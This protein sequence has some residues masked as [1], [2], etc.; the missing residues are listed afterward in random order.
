[1]FF[2]RFYDEGLAQASYLIGCD[3]SG[4]AVVVD[5]NR[6][7][8]QYLSA[9]AAERLRIT[10]VAETHIHADFVSG[11]RELAKR[12][13]A[14]LLLSAE[15][16]RD[17][18]Y[19]FATSDHATLLHDG[20]VFHADRV[21]FDV[22][23]TPGHTPEH[24]AFLVTDLAASDRPVGLLSGDCVFVGDVGRPDLLERAAKIVGTMEDSARA[25]FA[26]LKRLRELPDFVQLWPGHGAGSA[27]GKSLGAL[28]Q[29]TIGYERIANWGFAVTDEDAFVREVL[30]GQPEPPAYFAEMKRINREGPPFLAEW[31]QPERL[32]G[33]RLDAALS[34]RAVIVDLRSADSFADGHA[35]GTLNIPLSKSFTTWA[36]TLLPYGRDLYLIAATQSEAARAAGEMAKIGL[37]RVAGWFGAEALAEWSSGGGSVEQVT[38]A[39]ASGI[40]ARVTNGEVTVVDVRS[41]AEWAHGHLPGALHIPLGVL[42]ERVATIPRR[43]PVIVQCQGGARSAMAASV[44]QRHGVPDV[45]NLRGG[46]DEWRREALPIVHD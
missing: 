14:T 7:I 42:S 37:D 31:P 12:T 27:C 34:E 2:R 6:D 30:A 3:R 18:Q 28:P 38:Q 25:L 11:S 21:R 1:M 41:A 44:L 43:K 36:G 39:S 32:E 20:D 13:G 23:H 45:I 4:E 26:S 5:A 35:P 17:W 22:V 9:A 46:Y 16:G 19:A 33:H 8:A 40:A 24:L 29:S 15:G 10:K